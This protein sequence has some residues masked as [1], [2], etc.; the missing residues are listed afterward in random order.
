MRYP[1]IF[2]HGLYG[3]GSD[4]GIDSTLPYWGSGENNVIEFLRA[5]G[6]ECY[7]PS[8]GPFNSAW[9]RACILWAY[10]FGGQV[11]YGK[12]HSKKHGHARW[13]K[14]YPGVLKD[15]GTTEAHKKI[16]LIG[17]SF[18][19]ATVKEVSHLFADGSEEE[20]LGTSE[21]T[22]SPLFKGGHGDL[23]HTVT[24]LAGVDNGSTLATLTNRTGVSLLTIWGVFILSN[25]VPPGS[26]YYD[27]RLDQWKD[28][29]TGPID[30]SANELDNIA[31]EMDV[32]VV[33]KEV[34]P[35]QRPNPSTY[36]FAYSAADTHGLWK[37]TGDDP[38]TITGWCGTLIGH[39]VPAGM[40][41]YGIGVDK[42]WYR[43]DGF[44]NLNGARAPREWDPIDY[45]KGMDVQPG[46]WYNMPVVHGD[47]LYFNGMSGSRQDRE[48]MFLDMMRRYES[49]E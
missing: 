17:H 37:Q 34:N 5:H 1:N 36:Y 15:L 48:R 41:R 26:K 12:V 31:Q 25:M 29:I 35:K 40:W 49:L 16:N 22:L 43:N 19:G 23:I 46:Q 21:A 18:G 47:H 32:E 4:D 30:Y 20:R 3:W 44:V 13:G 11:D 39:Y 24:T 7:Y 27:F 28:G 38:A 6:Y 8:L 10:L 2:I 42:D 45:R 9:D 14:V 33:Q